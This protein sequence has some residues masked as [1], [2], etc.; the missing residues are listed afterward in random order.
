MPTRPFSGVIEGTIIPLGQ[1]RLVVTFD[2]Q[3]NYR[4]EHVDFD[5]AQIGLPYNAILGYPALAKFMAVTHHAYNIVKIPG[6]SGTITVRGDEQ[7][8][9]CLV[10][11]AYKATASSH[12]AEED[13]STL[14]ANPVQKKQL[15]TPEPT[16][17]KKVAMDPGTSGS[18]AAP[19]RAP[20]HHRRTP[21]PKVSP[22]NAHA[23]PRSSRRRPNRDLPA[24]ASRRL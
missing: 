4:T 16:K 14:S 10:E 21:H 8:A 5:V 3:E 24:R 2:T 18:G 11:H 7:N 23:A 19:S 12:P 1:I 17:G 22:K 20:H 15:V 9:L 6:C 13:I